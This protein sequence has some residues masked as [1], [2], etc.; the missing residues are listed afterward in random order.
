MPTSY[1][2]DKEGDYGDAVIL[3]GRQ[4]DGTFVPLKV[5]DLTHSSVTLTYPHHQ[6]HEGNLF[7]YITTADVAN[8]ASFDI[9]FNTNAKT[10]HLWVEGSAEA[11]FEFLVYET[12]TTADG[13]SWT[14]INRNRRSSNT[15]TLTGTVYNPTVSAVGDLLSK[16]KLGAGKD[17]SGHVKVAEL[18][19]KTETK[20]LIRFTNVSGGE[21]W[22]SPS[23]LWYENTAA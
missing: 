9:V 11:E 15:T 4:V 22:I 10:P 14:P 2:L 5:D 8:S 16:T 1:K 19:L 20:Y 21:V 18:I 23:L 3:Y 12:P 7:S 6:N 17:V 13:T